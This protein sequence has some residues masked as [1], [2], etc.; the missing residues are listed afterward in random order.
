MNNFFALTFVLMTIALIVF[1]VWQDQS[2]RGLSKFQ[3]EVKPIED[4]DHRSIVYGFRRSMV[5]THCE[6]KNTKDLIGAYGR[7]NHYLIN[8]TEIKYCAASGLI[9][10]EIVA[11]LTATPKQRTNFRIRQL[12]ERRKFNFVFVRNPLERLAAVYRSEM[13]RNWKV[14]G[15][16]NKDVRDQ[17]LLKYRKLDP[18]ELHEA[19]PPWPTETEFADFVIDAFGEKNAT[20]LDPFWIRPMWTL[21]PFCSFSFDI[22]GRMET[23][24]EDRRSILGRIYPNEQFDD[25]APEPNNEPPQRRRFLSRLSERQI[26]SLANLYEKDFDMFGYS[27]PRLLNEQNVAGEKTVDLKSVYSERTSTIMD[28][29]NKNNVTDKYEGPRSYF[30]YLIGKTEIYYCRMGKIASGTF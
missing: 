15:L 22:F 23:F 4:D 28:Y 18:S 3:T 1:I 16:A 20:D 21:C 19:K 24:K 27:K 7:F 6:E 2:Q 9:D 12:S 11:M 8:Q 29:C 26:Q 5:K 13:V 25:I 30:H 17:I 10:D 14:A